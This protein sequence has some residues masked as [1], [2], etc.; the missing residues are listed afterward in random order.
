METSLHRDLKQRYA[1]SDAQ[2]EVRIDG[3]RIDAVREGEL[4]EIQ[5]GSLAALRTKVGRLLADHRVRIVKPLVAR[6]RL[7]KRARLGGRVVSRRW[8]PKRGTLLDVFDE[9]IYFTGLF[10]HPRLILEIL[11]VEVEEWR[12]PGHGKR[13]RRRTGDYQVEDQKLVSAGE[14]TMLKTAADLGRLVPA[15]LPR[16]WHTG[17]LAEGLGVERWVAQRIAYCLRHAGSVKQVGKQG[18]A[19][20]YRPVSQRRAA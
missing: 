2:T 11:P 8:S 1:P 10:P 20:L 13:R 12:Y 16:P 15:D 9:L 6:K 18:N 7:V 14:A 4:I 3:Y 17:H 5:H 19:L